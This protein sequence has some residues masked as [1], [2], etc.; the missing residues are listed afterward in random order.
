M[1]TR[2]RNPRFKDFHLYGGRG[3][4]VCERW[5]TFANFYADMGTRPSPKHS[6]DRYPDRDGNYEPGNVRW[7]TAKEQARNTSRNRRIVCDGQQ[8]TLTEWSESTGLKREIIADR[9]NRGWPIRLALTT[10]PIRQR[11]RSTDGSFQKAFG[12]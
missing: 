8:K 2:C 3:I 10:N 6:L 5:L 4:A 7:T 1:L 9:L 11:E 12:D